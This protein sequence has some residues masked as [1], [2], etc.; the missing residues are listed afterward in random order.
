MPLTACSEAVRLFRSPLVP[1]GVG[2]ALSA[3][4]CKPLLP[5]RR[6]LG[7]PL[8]RGLAL[9]ALVLCRGRGDLLA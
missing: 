6:Q 3:L 5:D 1:G 2:L 8:W 9:T 7:E 4:R